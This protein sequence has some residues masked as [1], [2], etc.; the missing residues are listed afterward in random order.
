MGDKQPIRVLR[1]E[2]LQPNLIK[3]LAINRRRQLETEA[4]DHAT[5]KI[6]AGEQVKRILARSADDGRLPG[7]NTCLDVIKFLVQRIDLRLHLVVLADRVANHLRLR[8]D[9][10]EA[11]VA[12]IQEQHRR[13]LR[14]LVIGGG[15][16]ILVRNNQIRL[17]RGNRLHV[18]LRARARRKRKPPA[19]RER[20]VCI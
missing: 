17:E 11:A 4:D 3:R 2:L 15:V 10:I 9:V 5:G 16:A 18:R 8:E 7:G 6:I 20:G 1:E 13:N 12:R 14:Q 19:R